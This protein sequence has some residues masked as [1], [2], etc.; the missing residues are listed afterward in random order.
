M[1][2]VH[3]LRKPL[4]GTVAANV[5]K[6]GAG[7]LNIDGCRVGVEGGTKAVGPTPNNNNVYG[8]GMGGQA[9]KAA[10]GRWPANLILQAGC[11]VTSIDAQSGT[12][13]S[14]VGGA[15]RYFKIIHERK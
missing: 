10:G 8:E 12:P 2:V 5:I 11:P 7:A 4:S 3:V 1:K 15:S 14:D 9:Y 6:H 13:A